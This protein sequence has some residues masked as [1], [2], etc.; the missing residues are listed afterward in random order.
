MTRSKWGLLS[1]VDL[2]KGARINAIL[3]KLKQEKPGEVL[4]KQ[5]PGTNLLK[6]SRREVK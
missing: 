3:A 4:V 6:L 2:E 5:F 1:R